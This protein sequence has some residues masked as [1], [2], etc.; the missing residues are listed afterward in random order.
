MTQKTWS[1]VE[2]SAYLDGAL[3][4]KTR[5]AFEVA[6]GH[7]E[8]LRRKV[9]ALRATVNFVRDVPM[10]EPPRN[11]LLTPAMVRNSRSV[12]TKQRR[13]MVLWLRLATSLSAIAFA[14]TFGLNLLTGVSPKMA[15]QSA[16]DAP[17]GMIST[18]AEIEVFT[19]EEEVAE[20]DA[21]LPPQAQRSVSE[22]A[23]PNPVPLES[24]N[25]E[26]VNL[27]PAAAQGTP[28][29]DEQE[30]SKAAGEGVPGGATSTAS[31]TVSMTFAAS[32]PTQA[33]MVWLEAPP[34]SEPATTVVPQTFPS[35][36][37]TLILGVI[38]LVLAVVT[39]RISRRS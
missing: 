14:V 20:G 38:T 23:Q 9:D 34:T 28:Q 31:G 11:Y 33:P 21:S 7:D 19:V 26:M 32:S 2:I 1:A 6:L 12:S 39:F 25:G 37:I 29:M 27:A 22:E 5:A 15:P 3:D 36:W 35:R 4:N 18:T 8:I 30:S 10:R 17:A 16:Y 24:D 13:P